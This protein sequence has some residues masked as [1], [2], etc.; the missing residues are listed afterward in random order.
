M[1]CVHI[2]VGMC[3]Y[4][5]REAVPS[6]VADSPEPLQGLKEKRKLKTVLRKG[7]FPVFFIIPF[8]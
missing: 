7:S 4:R 8:S 2:G 6:Q 1:G 3:T 5:N